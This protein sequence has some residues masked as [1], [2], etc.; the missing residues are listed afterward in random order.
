MANYITKGK[1]QPANYWQ[2]CC[3]N[4]IPLVELLPGKKYSR[5]NY[6]I[7]SMLG[8]HELGEELLDVLND[9]YLSYTKFFSLPK[10]QYKAVGGYSALI[11][12]VFAEHGEFIAE[13]LFS[14]LVK[15]VRENRKPL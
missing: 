6:D 9:M 8:N 13:H 4:D 2:Y 12:T 3:E 15:Y 1:P 5:V 14:F 10:A 7:Y 11:I